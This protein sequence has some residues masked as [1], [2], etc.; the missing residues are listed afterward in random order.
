M[1]RF[2]YSVEIGLGVLHDGDPG[3]SQAYQFS[4]GDEILAYDHA[5]LASAGCV[6][7]SWD[8][9]NSTMGVRVFELVKKMISENWVHTRRGEK[10]NV[11]Y[12]RPDGTRGTVSLSGRRFFL[13]DATVQVAAD[14]L[15]DEAQEL[16]DEI[17]GDNDFGR[18]TSEMADVMGILV[19]LCCRLNFSIADLLRLT[20]RQLRANFKQPESEPQGL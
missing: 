15:V 10:V 19:H 6:G 13:G 1:S 3:E 7:V 17:H 8:E 20:E 5:G 14:N 12:E 9:L 18:V 16:Y 2:V 4:N 11:Q